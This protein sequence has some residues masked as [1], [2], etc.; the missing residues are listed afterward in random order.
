MTLPPELTSSEADWF[1]SSAPF[2]QVV[3]TSRARYARNLA[4]FPFAPHAEPHMLDAINQEICRAL[5]SVDYFDDY[6]RLE[7]A[8]VDVNGR[9]YLKEARL[10]SREMERGGAHRTVFVSR[11]LK[12]SIL[13]N[14]EDHLRI[15]C[16]ETGFQIEKVQKRLGEVHE[17]IA[18]VLSLSRHD[19]YGFLTACPTNVGSGLR[20]SAMMHL[21]GLTTSRELEKSLKGL[22]EIGLTVRGFHG[23]NS[24]NVGDYY[25]ISNEVTLGMSVQEIEERL[26]EVVSKLISQESEARSLLLSSGSVGILDSIWRSFGVLTH[27]RKIDSTE[28][29]KLISRLRLGIEGNFFPGL[30]HEKLN[31]L[32]LEIQPGHLIFRHGASDEP[33]ERDSIRAELIRNYLSNLN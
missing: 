17:H 6:L 10:I 4:N 32:I 5:E 27:A 16:L 9:A 15:Q 20:V 31:Q 18:R 23:E 11:D 8:D 30:T 1:A 22:P 33:T 29:M 19:R 28:A 2:H 24:E 13:I 14:E 7:V 21:P 25:Q 12:S 3:V 26:T